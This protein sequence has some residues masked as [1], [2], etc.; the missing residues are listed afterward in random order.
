LNAPG[1]WRYGA[2]PPVLL[3]P[4][5]GPLSWIWRKATAR[6]MARPGFVAPVPV[7]CC[8]NAGVGG[9][10]KTPLAID[11]AA[12]LAARGRH[13][14]LLTRGH[15]GTR[16]AA[17]RVDPAH[18]TAAEVGDEALLLAGAAPTWRGAD[19]A[20]TARLALRSGAGALVL[21][22]GL[23]NP[24]L[25]KTAGLMTI[26]G[27]YGFG[28]GRVLPSGP[29]RETVA[30]A[31]SRCRAAILIGEDQC[32]ALA[33]LPPS[34]PVLRA[35]LE[36]NA[37]DLAA[38]PARVLAF[39]G[40]GRPEKFFATLAEFGHTP[41]ETRSFADHHPYTTQDLAALRA[42][43]AELEAGLVTTAKDFARLP[44]AW[45]DGIAVLRVSLRWQ[46]EAALERLL[47]GILRPT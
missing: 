5:L 9:S 27:G 7:I 4:L 12:R 30:D 21:D 18:D 6:R 32:D 24:S 14:A 3:R 10:G 26:D 1:F 22:D 39:A 13:P 46:D 43:A 34:L 15:G 19:R 23:Q 33:Q 37:A 28:N 42:R 44:A 41:V 45:R 17:G 35:T 31:A 8:G 47:D 11:L 29:L 38:L 16:R 40:I 25:A 2:S 20:E 36:P